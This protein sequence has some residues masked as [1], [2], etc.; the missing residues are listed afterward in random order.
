LKDLKYGA[1]EEWRRSME[2]VVLKNEEVLHVD[3]EVK[4]IVR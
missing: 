1:G 2:P 4:N 3:R